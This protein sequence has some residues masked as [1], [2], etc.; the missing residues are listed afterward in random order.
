MKEGRKITV[1]VIKKGAAYARP[2]SAR[3]IKDQQRTIRKFAENN[4]I[5]IESEYSDSNKEE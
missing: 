4:G 5:T 2:C 1:N 3:P